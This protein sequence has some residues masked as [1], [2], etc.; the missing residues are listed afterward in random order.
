MNKQFKYLILITLALTIATTLA[1]A[2]PVPIGSTVQPAP[3]DSNPGGF[4]DDNTGAV[5]DAL[6]RDGSLLTSGVITL[7]KDPGFPN[8]PVT[9][10]SFELHTFTTPVSPQFAPGW[11]EIKIKYET[12]GTSN[13]KYKIEYST[14]GTIWAD[15]QLEVTGAA[16]AFTVA[17]R[18]WSQLAEP[19]DGLWTWSDVAGL[20]VRVFCTKDTGPFPAPA[21]DNRQMVI[22]EVW[23]TVYPLPLPPTSSTTVS[24]LPI[25]IMGVTPYDPLFAPT[26]PGGYC[27]A[28]VYVNEVAD[29]FNYEFW[30][31]FDTT[32]L[33]PVSVFVYYPWTSKSVE[34]LDDANGDIRISYSMPPPVPIGSGFTGNSPI[35]RVYFAVDVYGGGGGQYGGLGGTTDLW[36]RRPYPFSFLGDTTGVE[37]PAT[38]YDGWF[39]GP[40]VMS[41][42]G[43]LY[44]G[45]DPTG[46]SWHEL[47]PDYSK[48]W[49]VTDWE[50]N[51]EGTPDGTLSVSDQIAMTNATGWTFFFHVDVV[52]TTIHWVFKPGLSD[53][54]AAEPYMP[55]EDPIP[56]P[57]S[58]YWHQIYPDYCR[59]FVINSW[60]DTDESGTFTPSDQF[61]FEY[62]DEPGVTYD[63]HLEDVTTDIIVSQKPRDPEGPIAE[64]PL[65]LGMIMMIAPLIPIVYLLRIRKKVTK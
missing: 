37:I 14:D 30:I 34:T 1:Y 42:Q 7:G 31:K 40:H 57:I 13:D 49:Q 65:G 45:G 39:G 61:D 58:T 48:M 28:E 5:S 11:V 29:M 47:Y 17:I 12:P 62:L 44:P 43:S 2:Q 22:Y 21:W 33:T 56:N 35:F 19:T 64:F 16:S 18:P 60:T 54:G 46:T 41:Y 24:V 53:P 20:R 52:T 8:P 50:D 23:A 3:F 25:G 6:M 4:T 10:A 55:V 36:F 27:F 26:G 51:P 63:A 38:Y 32:V 9:T 59:W 15:L